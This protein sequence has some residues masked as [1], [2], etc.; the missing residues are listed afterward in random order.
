VVSNQGVDSNNGSLIVGALSPLE[1]CVFGRLK[2]A[3]LQHRRANTQAGK[4]TD[5]RVQRA[6][7]G[8]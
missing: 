6:S 8:S 5:T 1:F 2:V 7:G 4:N 3:K